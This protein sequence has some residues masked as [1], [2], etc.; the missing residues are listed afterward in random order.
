MPKLVTLQPEGVPASRS[1]VESVTLE[2]LEE[3]ER[4]KML[5]G[6]LDF[7]VRPTHL[8]IQ[9]PT[10]LLTHPPTNLL[11]HPT[12]HLSSHLLTHPPTHPPT[13]TANH[14]TQNSCGS[15]QLP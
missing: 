5:C 9:P 1:R 15:A 7:Q 3:Q 6:C 4:E 14:S 2:E 11:S 10:H 13:L 12:H 8:P